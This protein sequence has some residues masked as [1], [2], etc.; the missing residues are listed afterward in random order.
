MI[1]TVYQSL[2]V[3]QASNLADRIE[4]WS[5]TYVVAEAS[6]VRLVDCLSRINT[7][8]EAR[9]RRY[10]TFRAQSRGCSTIPSEREARVHRGFLRAWIDGRTP[11]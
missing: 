4:V 5:Y 7:V 8:I 11:G 9:A 3:L 10:C 1:C 2:Q 6:L